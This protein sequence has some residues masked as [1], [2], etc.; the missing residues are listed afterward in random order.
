MTPLREWLAKPP[1][2]LLAVVFLLTAASVSAVVWSGWRLYQQDS[3][4][5]GQRSQERLEQAAS[6]IATNLRG[7]LAELGE[8][9]GA[10]EET[11][12]GVEPGGLFLTT[13]GDSLTVRSGGPLLYYPNQ[14]SEPDAD[15]VVFA[16]AE[17]LEF[18][19][20]QPLKALEE[21]RRLGTSP[22]LA[23]RAGAL[24]REAR[25][26]RTSGHE[27][28]S[29]DI[30]RRL[31]S[32]QGVR[33][34]GTPAD[35]VGR[36]E[37]GDASIRTDL[38]AGRWHLT[39]GQFDFYWQKVASEQAAPSEAIALTEAVH[40]AWEHRSP[41]ARGQQSIWVG[42]HPWLM[43]WRGTLE[44]RA[45][46]VT[47]PETFLK[48]RNTDS[49][50]LWALADTDGRIVA[51]QH[52]GSNRAVV[53]AAAE[54]QLPWTLYVSSPRPAEDADL[55]ASK[56]FLVLGTSAM[57]LFLILGAYFIA[58]VIRREAETARMQSDFVAAVSHEFRSPLTSLRQLSEMLAEGRVQSAE[59]R[60]IYYETLVKETTR[61]QRLVEGVLNFERMDAGVK[62]YRFEELD[63]ANLVQRVVSEF[64]PHVTAHGRRIEANQENGVYPIEGDPE[65]ICVALRN[66]LDNALK[67]SPG[68]PTVW[69]HLGR[70]NGCVAIRVRDTGPGIT[71]AERKSIFRRF[72]RGS[73]ARATN[74]NGSGVG[75]AM[76][77]HIVAAHGGQITLTSI[78]GEGSIFTML[79][80]A[81]GSHT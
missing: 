13:T 66:L 39:R 40:L 33:I 3:I 23:V 60:Q 32:M 77:R 61:L 28:E 26:Q 35:L 54:T 57:V 46:L 27:G 24:L 81:Y 5:Q 68:Q 47:R 56:R 70:Q 21:Y 74:A 17:L 8:R 38:L 22:N 25:V 58:R 18:A 37:L 76:V 51:G 14:S 50:L 7:A 49:K 43:V 63:A 73:A 79:L 48:L 69:V 2:T 67:Y 59:R 65:A 75:L 9:L 15:P 36:L 80:P 72:V 29:L 31:A 1:G 64:E 41:E 19:Q 30:Y 10:W 71:D 6:H 45:L 44:R 62:H 11:P 16:G 4:V 12:P 34:A 55:S 52:R 78:P 42:G 20:G 53:R